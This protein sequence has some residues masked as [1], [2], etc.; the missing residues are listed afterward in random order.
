MIA[1]RTASLLRGPPYPSSPVSRRYP[2]PLPPP[3]QD[4]RTRVGEQKDARWEEA[5]RRDDVATRV[6]AMS[7]EGGEGRDTG[8]DVEEAAETAG[9][10][11]AWEVAV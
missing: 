7:V 8:L 9:E 11:K 3:S 2:P 5:K 4:W 10:K 6:A 1:G